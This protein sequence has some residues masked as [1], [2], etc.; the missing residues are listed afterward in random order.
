MSSDS[1][2]T[3]LDTSGRLTVAALA[4]DLDFRTTSSLY[5]EAAELATAHPRLVLDLSKVTFC[6]SSGLNMLLRLRRRVSENDGWLAVAAP[7]AQTLRLMTVTGADQVI[8]VHGSLAE[9][10][11]AAPDRTAE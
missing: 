8:P 7:P 10:L 11:A 1:Q 3:V 5:P 2:L 4:G 9:A 6:D